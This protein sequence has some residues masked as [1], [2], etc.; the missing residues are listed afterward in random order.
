MPASDFRIRS[1]HKCC[2]Y[3]SPSLLLPDV[4]LHMFLGEFGVYDIPLSKDKGKRGDSD[5]HC[6]CRTKME[7]VGQALHQ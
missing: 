3:N 1:R 4:W 2:P 5:E 6:A 7:C